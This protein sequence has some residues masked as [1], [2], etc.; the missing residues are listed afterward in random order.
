MAAVRQTTSSI[1]SL[2]EITPFGM[3]TAEHILKAEMEVLILTG[4]ALVQVITT[5]IFT[6]QSTANGFTA[7]QWECIAGK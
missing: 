5:S 3:T 4:M 6:K 7:M 1:F 2:G